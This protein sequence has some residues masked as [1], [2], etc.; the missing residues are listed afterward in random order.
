MTKAMN[1]YPDELLRQQFFEG[2]SH[3]AC[4][5]N[6]VTTVGPAGRAGV[7]VSAMSSVSA[8]TFRPSL[9]VCVHHMSPAAGAILE[10][11]VFCVNVLRDDQ[12]YISDTF[13]G[14]I[15]TED[16]DK[17]SCTEWLT[18]LTGAPRVKNPLV[19]F[20]C[21]LMH[22]EQVGTHWVF[23]GAVEDIHV[24]RRGSPLIYANRA[25][26]TST[27]IEPI[28][29]N[30]P[31]GIARELRAGCFRTFAPYVIP[32][33][34][35]GV[36]REHPSATLLLRDGSQRQILE[37]LHSGDTEIALLYDFDLGLGL[38]TELLTEIQPYV[39]LPGGH[40][41]AGR[42][43][44]DLEALSD[45]PLILLD[46]PP[47]RDYF[48]SV[49]AARGVEPR[50]GHRT[51]SF[52]VVRGLVGHGFGYSLLATKPASDM[53]Y[54]GRGLATVKLARE[55]PGSR[56]V[57]ARKEN[58]PLSRV[59]ESFARQCRFFFASTRGTDK[60]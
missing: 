25:Y 58:A 33:L 53:S 30:A 59:A 6:V 47:S 26:G 28:A 17:F 18:G 55:A 11:E 36:V 42:P 41:L 4:T 34:L 15:K 5:V 57:L 49:F 20:D 27:P 16:N 45:E 44:I 56:I 14:R 1:H 29:G 22:S 60:D 13:A 2:M 12:S 3:A 24:A 19:A 38:I 31:D 51:S 43:R 21:S 35:T 7:T 39:L 10:N 32:E 9:L 52:E 8:D 37:G 48:L 54:D 46:S 40:P 50:I 23:F